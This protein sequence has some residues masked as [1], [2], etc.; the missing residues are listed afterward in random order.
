MKYPYTIYAPTRMIIRQLTEMGITYVS[1]V[2][3]NELNNI[4]I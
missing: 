1:L 3:S 4:N 2:L